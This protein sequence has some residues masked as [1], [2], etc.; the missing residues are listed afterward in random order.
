MTITFICEVLGEEN[1]G[2][3]IATMNVVRYLRSKGHDVHVVCPDKDKKGK[4]GYLVIPRIHFGPFDRYVE[5]NGVTLS[6][7]KGFKKNEALLSL[8]RKSDVIHFNFGSKLTLLCA[9][10]AHEHGIPCTASFHTQAENFTNHVGLM[11]NSFANFL[12]YCVLNHRLF[13]Q[14]DSIHYP[15]QFVR[16]VFRAHHKTGAKEYIISNGTQSVFHREKVSKPAELEGKYIITSTGRYSTEKQQKAL[17]KSMRYSAHNKDIQLIFPG[18]GPKRKHMEKLAE[19]YCVNKPMFGFHSREHLAE[20]LNY[21]DLYCHCSYAD[22]EAIS[23]LEAISVGITPVLSDSPLSAV[24]GF[25]LDKRNVY[26]HDDPKDLAAH[27]DYWL[28]HPKERKENSNLYAGLA[29]K[30]ALEDMMVKMEAMF[31]ETIED[32]KKKHGK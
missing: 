10:Y 22:L 11:R 5:K 8:I 16:N 20:I 13:S 14:V 23:C 32:Y 12:V 26:H 9:Q 3:T 28:D 27:I 2:T 24:S 19:K 17:I 31:L 4:E 18:D 15:T 21:T 1:N 29:S 7:S 30:Y 6:S 25:A